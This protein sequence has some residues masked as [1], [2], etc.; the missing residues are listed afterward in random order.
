[1]GDEIVEVDGTP[2]R[3]YAET[4]IDPYI[5]S[6]TPQDRLVRQYSY[7]LLHGDE[8]RPI[9]LKIKNQ[10][11]VL[12]QEILP[13]KG[14]TDVVPPPKNNFKLLPGNIAYISVDDFES[15]AAVLAFERAFP[16]I[17][18][19]RGLIIDV[20]N[21][22]G[23]SSEYGMRIL[24]FLTNKPIR[25]PNSYTRSDNGLSRNDRVFIKWTPLINS[26]G[27]DTRTRPV[28]FSGP[29]TVL[30]G[31]KTFS[32]AEDFV[33]AFQ[34][35]LRGT[36]IGA[37]TGGS[38]GQ[39][40]MVKLPG[41]GSGRICAKRDTFADGTTFVGKGLS[42]NIVVSQTLTD[43]YKGS[44]TVLARAVAEFGAAP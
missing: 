35:A 19:A 8:N 37:A 9:G 24:R 2:V 17:L 30:T 4:Y 7:Q 13:R 15:D 26:G 42:P 6:S 40:I 10:S 34:T 16:N 44:D 20:R 12:R 39:P 31:P 29:V 11:G 28:V 5:S 25:G 22:G 32:A 36:T 1:V 41:G 33:A 38:T 14:Y 27:S 3:A 18:K 21:N 43:F 23:G